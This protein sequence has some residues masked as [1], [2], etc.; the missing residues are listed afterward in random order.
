MPERWSDL[1]AIFNPQGWP[2]DRG[3]WRMATD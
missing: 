3:C 1:D 2:V